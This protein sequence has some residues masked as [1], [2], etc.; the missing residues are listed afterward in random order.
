MSGGVTSPILINRTAEMAR[1]VRA[2]EDSKAGEPRIVLLAGEAGIG[3]S[4]LLIEG[5][6]I[7]QREGLQRLVGACL[8]LGDG[9]IPYLP[10]AEALRRH[11]R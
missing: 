6:A 1:L 10:I 2:W 5:D 7:V 9:A 8:A 3:K 11:V 4:R